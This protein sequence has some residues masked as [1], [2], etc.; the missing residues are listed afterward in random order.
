M[1][2]L[3][4]EIKGLAPIDNKSKV[5]AVFEILIRR[6]TVVNSMINNMIYNYIKDRSLLNYYNSN[7]AIVINKIKDSTA[8]RNTSVKSTPKKRN[9]P[10]ARPFSY[11]GLSKN[12]PIRKIMRNSRSGNNSF[13]SIEKSKLEESYEY[14]LSDW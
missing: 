14:G 8:T 6:G 10:N 13:S 3:S 9:D 4:S 5:D 12:D 1:A 11:N 7:I 2:K